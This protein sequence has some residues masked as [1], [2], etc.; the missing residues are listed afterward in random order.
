MDLNSVMG[1]IVG[2]GKSV[3]QAAQIIFTFGD[4]TMQCHQCNVYIGSMWHCVVGVAYPRL[5]N[6]TRLQ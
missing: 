1:N 6:W 3:A 4:E 2:P 5:S